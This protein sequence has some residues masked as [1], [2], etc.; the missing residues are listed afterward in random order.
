[1]LLMLDRGLSVF[2]NIPTKF[3]LSELDLQ[4]PCRREVFETAS[5]N[6]MGNTLLY[7]PLRMKV[8]EAFQDLFIEVN[9]GSRRHPLMEKETWCAFDLQILIHSK[10][11]QSDREIRP[12]IRSSSLRFSLEPLV[13]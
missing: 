11:P 9:A 1:M 10:K 12:L 4:F 5:F 13:R 6:P 2:S 8:M 3:E 7:P